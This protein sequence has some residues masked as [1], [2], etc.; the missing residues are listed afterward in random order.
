MA[1]VSASSLATSNPRGIALM[2]VSVMMF[3]VMDSLVKW[4]GTSYPIHQIVFFRCAVALVPC[5]VFIWQAGGL[6][7]LHTDRMGMH[8]LRAAVG[9]GSMGLMFFAYA[10][11]KIADAVAVFFSAPLFLTA[12]SGPL[13]GERVGL[14]RW[15][16]VLVGFIG[17]L[18]IVNP[19]SDVLSPGALAALGGALGFAIAMIVVRKLSK[20]DSVACISFW[21]T[22]TGTVIGALLIARFGWVTPSWTD[23]MLLCLVG[24]IGGI[25]QQVMTYAFRYGESSVVA[26]MEYTAMIWVTL[27]GY[28]VWQ[29]VPDLR[30]LL[31]VA[32]VIASGLY[33]LY[34]EAL[35]SG[36]RPRRLPR[37][38]A[39]H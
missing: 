10:H 1:S 4:L 31:G 6:R 11:M 35:L 22:A 14:R 25:G 20:T 26:P 9:L 30:T 8:I 13:L 39:R 27:I 33:I 21:F 38:R 7:T 37:L 2:L 34:R 5:S 29:E 16:A 36:L 32:I 15:S 24:L 19:S 28:V 18:V 23:L 12:L 3:C 17:V